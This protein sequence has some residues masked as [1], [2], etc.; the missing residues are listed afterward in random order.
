LA[1]ILLVCISELMEDY[2]IKQEGVGIV[3]YYCHAYSKVHEFCRQVEVVQKTK[4][5][6]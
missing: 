5:V 2:G 3:G 4:P 6:S 1:A